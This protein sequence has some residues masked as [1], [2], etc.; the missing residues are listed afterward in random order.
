MDMLSTIDI[1]IS[2][3]GILLAAG[4]VF[5]ASPLFSINAAYRLMKSAVDTKQ[6]H[7]H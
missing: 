6:C 4:G 2:A 7:M 1:V 3:G 5:G